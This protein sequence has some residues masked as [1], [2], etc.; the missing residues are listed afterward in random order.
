MDQPKSVIGL[1]GQ[2]ISEQ[3]KLLEESE[4]LQ[5]LNKFVKISK[6]IVAH[7]KYIQEFESVDALNISEGIILCVDFLDAEVGMNI[8]YVS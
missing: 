2:R 1:L 7:Q 8:V 6:L 5:K 3:I 4:I